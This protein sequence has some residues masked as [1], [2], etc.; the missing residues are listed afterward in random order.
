MIHYWIRRTYTPNPK[1]T[2]SRR[3]PIMSETHPSTPGAAPDQFKLVSVV[4]L[5][6]FLGQMIL[7]PVIAPLSRSLG[8]Q[9]WHVGAMISIAAVTLALLSQFWGRRS[10]KVGAKKVFLMSTILAAMALVLFAIISWL[11]M[12]GIIVGTSL[13]MLMLITRGIFYGGAISAI[14][15]TAMAYITSTTSDEKDRLRQLGAIGAMQALSGMVGAFLGGAL[16]AFHLMAPLI[17]MPIMVLCATALVAMKMHPYR[18]DQLIEEPARISYTDKRVYPFLIAGFLLFIA[19]GTLTIIVGFV[20]QDRFDLDA[21]QTAGYSAGYILLTSV[22]MVITQ[23]VVLPKLNLS[24][25]TLLRL[26]L[27]IML[28]AFILLLIPA[29]YVLFGVAYFLAGAGAGLAI[30]GYST[31]PTLL[32]TKEEQGGIGGIINATNGWTYALAP[33]LCT[34]LYGWNPESPFILC[35]VLLAIA[36]LFCFMHPTLRSPKIAQTP[37]PVAS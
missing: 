27:S 28:V 20:L 10:L 15:P 24:A 18:D 3:V 31:G 12:K 25:R 8:L 16:G 26:G 23:A 35:V 21:G 9:E 22:V 29:G 14:N 5:L 4:V 37:A 36:V 2:E 32:A 17:L 19:F 7:N 34:S 33:I 13:F 1:N 30:P 6:A 11:G